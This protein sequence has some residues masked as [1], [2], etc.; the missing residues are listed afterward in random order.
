[1]EDSDEVLV[2]DFLEVIDFVDMGYKRRIFLRPNYYEEI[3][4]LDSFRRLTKPT[5]MT[6]LTQIEN[7]LEYPD[8]RNNSI[9][10][11]NQLLLTLRL[12]ASSGHMIQTAD[13]MNVHV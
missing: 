7:Q 13:Y 12:Y 3:P 11:L 8:D 10:P 6:L 9:W 5:A 2:E 4:Q 1:M